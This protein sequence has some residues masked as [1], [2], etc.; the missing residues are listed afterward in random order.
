MIDDVVKVIC[1]ANDDSF[2]VAGYRVETVRNSL[3]DAFNIPPQA[4]AVVNGERVA[5]SYILQPNDILE[6]CKQSGNKGIVRMFTENEIRREYTG[7]PMDVLDGLF[8]SLRHDDT[9][10]KGEPIWLESSVDDWLKD[11]YSR[12]QA[13][14][15]R[16]KVIPPNGVRIAGKVYTNL[17]TLE[18]RLMDVLLS[19]ADRSVEPGKVIE[20][21]YGHDAGDKDNALKLVIKRLNNKLGDQEFPFLVGSVNGSVS[22]SR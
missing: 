4:I 7:F 18:W 2:A 17:T 6:F 1:G 13:D 10:S 12:K 3:V 14:D 15:G 9:N 20:H 8:K 5:S 19:S 11:Q 21:V 22:I 16:D